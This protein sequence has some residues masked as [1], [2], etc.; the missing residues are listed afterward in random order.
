M[1]RAPAPDVL[2]MRVTSFFPTG[3][4]RNYVTS[5]FVDCDGTIKLRRE[6]KKIRRE[7]KNSNSKKKRV[8]RQKGLLLHGVL[9][10]HHVK[11]ALILRMQ[12]NTY[13][14]KRS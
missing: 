2:R 3:S 13:G 4:E 9:T 10:L 7:K 1:R 6:K 8:A 12:L 5:D 11:A 14:E